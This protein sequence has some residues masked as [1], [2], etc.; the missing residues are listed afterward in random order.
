MDGTTEGQ[1]EYDRECRRLAEIFGDA[2]PTQIRN[3]QY[4]L[5]QGNG[6]YATLRRLLRAQE[7][8]ELGEVDGTA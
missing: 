3:T 5:D 8:R 7:L 4:R 1:R 2:L 6:D